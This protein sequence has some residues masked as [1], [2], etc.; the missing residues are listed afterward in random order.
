MKLIVAL[1]NPGKNYEN[2]RHNTGYIIID[3]YLKEVKWSKKFN[4]LYYKTKINNEDVCFIK[5]L[6]F[7][8]LSGLS[9]KKFCDFYKVDMDNILIIQDDI[10]MKIGT[11]K[12]KN[13][14]S[15]G[16]HNGI[17]SIIAE[18]NSDE[19]GR[20]KVGISSDN[21]ENNAIEIVLG[22]FSKSELDSLN[23]PEFIKIINLFI[24]NGFEKAKEMYK[25]V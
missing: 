16:G 21:E 9:V 13:N 5:P 22:K 4:S 14:S 17:K 3:N 20:L 18:L 6:T 10:D 23:N 15:S 19:F 8:N 1:G 2:T 12:L 24:E 11:Y 25:M 7:M